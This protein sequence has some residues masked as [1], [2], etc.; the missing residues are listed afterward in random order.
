MA[1]R[2]SL[3]LEMTFPVLVDYGGEVKRL[4]AADVSSGGML[5]IAREPIRRGAKI[6]V[7]FNLPS[8]DVELEAK[9]EVRHVSWLKNPDQ[10]ID[11]YF[12]M[13]LRFLKFEQGAL[14][15]PLRCL[16]S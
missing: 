16:P 13:G 14:H 6:R 2:R 1:D 12:R 5:V 3:R 7:I 8:T 9:A 4:M 11:G 10:P 15:P